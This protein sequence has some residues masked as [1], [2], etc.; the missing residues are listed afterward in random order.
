MQVGA[1]LGVGHGAS[2][3]VAL[4]VTDVSPDR[5]NPALQENVATLPWALAL[6]LLTEPLVGASAPLPVQLDAARQTKHGGH[7]MR[8]SR[9]E[10]WL[11]GW[12]RTT[13]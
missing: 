11:G 9:V 7:T 4:H 10:E 3:L 2:A 1:L 5:A 13:E 8:G 12:V 6:V